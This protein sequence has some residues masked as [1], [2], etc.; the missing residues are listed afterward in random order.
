[1]LEFFKTAFKILTIRFF[2]KSADISEGELEL[3]PPTPQ[4]NDQSIAVILDSDA[5]YRRYQPDKHVDANGD[6]RPDF[7]AFPDRK[8]KN[9]SGQSFLL[10]RLASVLHA[11]H[12][13][14]NEGKRLPPGE[15]GVLKLSV[16]D[17][18]KVVPGPENQ[19]FHFKVIHTPYPSCRAHC[20]L[21][22]SDRPNGQEYVVPGKQVKTQLRILLLRKF[23][24]TA[25]RLVAPGP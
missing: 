25:A 19:T 11:L 4:R 6:L 17:I 24:P 2:R 20:E 5:L 1:M 22:C 10:K 3:F 9:K 13:N 18:P 23:Q 21:F 16:A 12:R 7:F 15:W 14:C 8:D